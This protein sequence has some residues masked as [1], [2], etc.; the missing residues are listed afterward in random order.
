MCGKDRSSG[1]D[2]MAKAR[3]MRASQ[4]RQGTFTLAK[5]IMN[6]F[7]NVHSIFSLSQSCASESPYL[8]SV[9]TL[10]AHC[11][12]PHPTKLRI[13]Q[14]QQRQ[15]F[16]PRHGYTPPHQERRQTKVNLVP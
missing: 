2:W 12:R 9:T 7:V 1:S 8:N 6:Q 14:K 10:T 16:F 4:E 13:N 15:K 11:S 3:T 5:N